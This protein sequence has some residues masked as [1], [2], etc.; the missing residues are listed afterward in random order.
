MGAGGQGVSFALQGQPRSMGHPW[1]AL[2]VP[3]P[4]CGAAAAFELL[5]PY[6][7]L[8]I[9]SLAAE[10]K[11]KGSG[12]CGDQWAKVPSANPDVLSFVPRIQM[13]EEEK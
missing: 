8:L 4:P 5:L 2:G 1:A 11:N 7:R 6:S 13:V 3:D 9:S 10:E 12:Q